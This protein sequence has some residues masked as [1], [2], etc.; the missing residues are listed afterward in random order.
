MTGH[1]RETAFLR[2]AMLYDDTVE[3]HQLEARI[4]QVERN[5]QCVG[6]AVWLMVQLLLLAVAGLGFAAVLLDDFPQNKSHLV[7]KVLCALGLGS[8]ICLLMFVTLW[9]IYRQQLSRGR[10]QG[11]QMVAKL[12]ESRLGKP[13][14]MP[15]PGV[16]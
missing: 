5:G 1:Q 16:V 8:L 10:E 13:R 3:R 6:R 11:C 14:T 4:V 2:Q 9:I 12:L 15:L 7:I